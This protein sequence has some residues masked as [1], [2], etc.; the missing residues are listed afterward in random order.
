MVLYHRRSIETL[1]GMTGRFPD[2]ADGD[3]LQRLADTGIDFSR[4]M[5]IN[6]QVEVRD[7]SAARSV[8]TI[9]EARGYKVKT[10]VDDETG[11][12]TVECTATMYATYEGVVSRQAELT[13]AS[14]AFGGSCDAWGTYGND[15]PPRALPSS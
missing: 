12:I 9:A 10:Y 14:R 15:P 8:A 4:P 3:T 1:D 2:D 13:D 11:D 6:F 5:D 7:N